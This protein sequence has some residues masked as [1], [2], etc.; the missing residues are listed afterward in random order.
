MLKQRQQRC[1]RSVIWRPRGAIAGALMGFHMT[2]GIAF[3]RPMA[4]LVED[5]AITP[6]VL[7]VGAA[8]GGFV[9]WFMAAHALRHTHAERGEIAQRAVTR[10]AA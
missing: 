6:F 1:N 5:P 7:A 4:Y 2:L 3:V 9:S 8:L 10:R